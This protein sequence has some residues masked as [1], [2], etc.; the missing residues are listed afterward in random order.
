MP[1][2]TQRRQPPYMTVLM[3]TTS[4]VGVVLAVD[5]LTDWWESSLSLAGVH[6]LWIL[7]TGLMLA[8][9]GVLGIVASCPREEISQSYRMESSGHLLAGAGWLLYWGAVLVVHQQAVVSWTIG[10]GLALASFTQLRHVSRQEDKV[11]G[12][13]AKFGGRR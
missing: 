11:R 7:L 9:G 5:A 12:W 1:G 6:S 3:Y 2:F 10:L 4:A 13:V 8:A